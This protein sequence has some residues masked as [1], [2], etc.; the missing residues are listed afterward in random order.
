MVAGLNHSLNLY[1]YKRL[2]KFHLG[3]KI[4]NHFGCL[5]F[6]RRGNAK[7]PFMSAF[8][9]FNP[10][11][12][13]D[14][15]V[16]SRGNVSIVGDNKI[17]KI[18]WLNL[19]QFKH[20]NKKNWEDYANQINPTS[21]ILASDSL[22]GL[23]IDFWQNHKTLEDFGTDAFSWCGCLIGPSNA[24]CQICRSQLE[25]YETKEQ[26]DSVENSVINNL[27]RVDSII[28]VQRLYRSKT[29]PFKGAAIPLKP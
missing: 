29:L 19:N 4:E 24:S 1:Y 7:N 12:L 17:L 9:Y 14:F 8:G 15:N 6:L 28:Y 18:R 26:L 10:H 11:P 3:L 21:Y 22:K 2:Q 25:Y 23:T 13:H 16:D 27:Q 5:T 20:I